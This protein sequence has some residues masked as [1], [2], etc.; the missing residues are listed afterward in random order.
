M[1]NLNIDTEKLNAKKEE[2]RT[3]LKDLEILF[4]KIK[5]ETESLKDVWETRTSENVFNGFEEFYE[6]VESIKADFEKDIAF[7]EEKVNEQYIIKENDIKTQI[8]E[9]LT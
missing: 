8:D 3:I 6:T 9:K 7:I 5:K 4:Q 2:I 1:N